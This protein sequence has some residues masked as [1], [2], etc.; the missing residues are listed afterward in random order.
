MASSFPLRGPVPQAKGAKRFGFGLLVVATT[1]VLVL[2]LSWR[3]WAPS[4]RHATV[5]ATGS[6]PQI[7]LPAP[8]QS[9]TQWSVA[10]APA[11]N[12][13]TDIATLAWEASTPA[14]EFV[15]PSS[16]QVTARV[17]VG[18][19]A[20]ALFRRSAGQLIVSDAIQPTSDPGGPNGGL[21]VGTRLL[22]FD[23]N[24]GLQLVA[25]LPIPNRLRSTAYGQPLVL[26]RDESRLAYV[27]HRYVS[28]GPGC[29]QAGGPQCDRF[30]LVEVELQGTPAV[31]GAAD[32]PA[33]SYPGITA[34]GDRGFAVTLHDST[35]IVFGSDLR[36]QEQVSFAQSVAAGPDYHESAIPSFKAGLLSGVVTS[37]G[38]VIGISTDGFSL[39]GQQRSRL[40]PANTWLAGLPIPLG[41]DRYALAFKA[42]RNLPEVDGVAIVD[43]ATAA[44]VRT[45]RFATATAVLPRASGD[46]FLIRQGSLTHLPAGRTAEM[47][48]ATVRP[49]A[50]VLIP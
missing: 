10:A 18:D 38:E 28:S 25:E 13:A 11:F 21:N 35:V 4:G 48:V 26:A 2:L 12:P 3:P 9:G 44:V 47:P 32:L 7:S 20:R 27:E 33:G 15:S 29:T 6:R 39:H 19:S 17:N 31:L 41:G 5:T 43:V 36:V 37:N 30:R 46:V 23:L 22:I 40:T 49:D 8:Q 50:G 34:A 14:V 42:T 16:G 45:I 24:R 1:I